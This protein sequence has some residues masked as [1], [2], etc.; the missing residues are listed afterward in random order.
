MSKVMIELEVEQL[1]A[2]VRNDL[3]NQYQ[4]AEREE[5]KQALLVVIEYY[6]TREQYKEFCKKYL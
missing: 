6:S 4:W 2:I 5:V 1:E 3:I